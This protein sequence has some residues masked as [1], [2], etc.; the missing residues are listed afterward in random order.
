MSEGLYD[1]VAT[2]K[3]R[4][5]E[6]VGVDGLGPHLTERHGTKV[7]GTTTLDGGVYRVDRG[8]DRPWVARLFPRT[9]PMEAVR[10]DADVLEL[11]AAHGFPA[12]RCIDDPVSEH[13]GQGVLVT[14][15]V[16]GDNGR[17][18]ATP[19]RLHALGALLGALH[20][21]TVPEGH[22]A[23]R[24]AGSWHSLSIEGGGRDADVRH[25]RSLLADASTSSSPSPAEGDAFE[26][27]DRELAA[28]DVGEGLPT[29]LTHPDFCSANAMLAP[30]GSIVLVDWTGAGTA[31]R[32]ISLG[33][34]LGSTGGQPASI[35]AVMSGYLS[36][37]QALQ[38]AELHR[39]DDAVFGF[40]FVL[41]CWGVIYFGAPASQVA[42]TVSMSRA[43]ARSIA[44]RAR[45]AA[46]A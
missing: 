33:L 1:S 36:T 15:W 19:A 11:V 44:D 24:A 7:T 5:Y 8:T 28:L 4:A 6:R 43:A 41:A 17:G 40:G 16:D 29:A 46:A 27:L 18:N 23:S 30:D 34:L 21:I 10:G 42:S 32:V 31:P 35:D 37:G 12:E 45:Q 9:R 2:F 20:A 25:L 26:T 14:E 39:L 3:A 22:A 38:E 13:D